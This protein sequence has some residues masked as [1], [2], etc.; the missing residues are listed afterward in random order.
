M[1]RRLLATGFA[2]SLLVAHMA[3]PV[4]ETRTGLETTGVASSISIHGP[5]RAWLG[6]TVHITAVAPAN[7]VVYVSFHKKGQP[8]NYFSVRRNLRADMAGRWS[9]TY[10][11]DTDYRYFAQSGSAKSAIVLTQTNVVNISGPASAP[12]GTVVPVRGHAPPLS[13]VYVYF[14]R[15][16]QPA[17]LYTLRRAR[18]I[19]VARNLVHLVYPRHGLSVL[20]RV[21][22]GRNSTTLLTRSTTIASWPTPSSTGVPRS[23]SLTPSGSGDYTIARK[24]AVLDRVHISGDL[25]IAADDVTVQNSEVDG[26]VINEVGSSHFSFTIRDST[27]GPESGC[28]TA[29]GVGE[30][31]F[32][33]VRVL[34][35]GHDD[36]FRMSGNH[37]RV[38]D[39]YARL[40]AN[41][42]SHSDGIQAYCPDIACTGLGVR[43]Q[44]DRREKR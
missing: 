25:V 4:R 30:S 13:V 8:A 19:D 27:V 38:R 2:A 41:S 22:T 17:S 20:R 32:S 23:A 33:A 6:A 43:P 21:R 37:V 39:S 40:C 24:G 35:R 29:P 7:A 42:G 10:K 18:S 9:T 3:T 14:H 34:V 1:G 16:G 5:E 15:K 26:T 28:I 31:D 11:Q 36:G 12:T 44:H